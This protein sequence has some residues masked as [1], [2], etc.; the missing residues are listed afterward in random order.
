M[1]QNIN[2]GKNAEAVIAKGVDINVVDPGGT[3]EDVTIDIVA[4]S[5]SKDSAK[6]AKK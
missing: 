1:D 2:A 5:K 3:R 4:N 6:V